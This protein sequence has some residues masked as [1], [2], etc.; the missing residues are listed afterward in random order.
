MIPNTR[1]AL[2]EYCLRKLGKGLNDINITDEQAD[3]RIDDVIQRY[4]DFAANGTIRT[5]FK[6]QITAEDI[7]NQFIPIPATITGVIRVL[8]YGAGGAAQGSPFNVE[9]Q[10]RMNDMFDLGATSMLYYTQVMQHLDM[11]DMP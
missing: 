6:H 3:D 2:K 1:S 8:Q 5:Y 7:A 11:I 9:Y 10:L 4:Q